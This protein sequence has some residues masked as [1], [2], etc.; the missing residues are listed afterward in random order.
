MKRRICLSAGSAFTIFLI[1]GCAVKPA[2]SGQKALENE[3]L[4]SPE[5][6][7]GRLSLVIEPTAGSTDPAQSFSGG[8][9]IRGNAQTGEL[10][11]LTPLGQI[12]MQ[13]RWL[14]D[15][16]VIFRG[17][18]RQIFANAQDLILQATGAT[19]SLEQLFAWLQGKETHSAAGDWRV[20]LSAQAQGRIIARRSLPSPAVL[21]IALEKP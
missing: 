5:R 9:E 19:L 17:G 13:L 21:R 10:D 4:G 16:A 20:D 6:Y 7:A 1:A 15:I 18:K 12:V 8:F 3:S 11:L 14:P 2:E